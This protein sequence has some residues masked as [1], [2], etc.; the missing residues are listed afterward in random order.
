M[1][2]EAVAQREGI[3]QPVGRDGD[4]VHHFGLRHA[5][6]VER[7]ELVVDHEA[8]VAHESGGGQHRVEAGERAD[9]HH[10]QR[11]RRRGLRRQRQG[12]GG[13]AAAEDELSKQAPR[14]HGGRLRVGGKRASA[15]GAER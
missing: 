9:L 8:V 3:V 14:R 5:L 1:E 13:K 12:G 10:A 11:R 7:E 6:A 2:A 4:A 15:A